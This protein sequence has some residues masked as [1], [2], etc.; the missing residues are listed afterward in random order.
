M[1]LVGRWGGD[2]RKPLVQVE[3]YDDQHRLLGTFS[4]ELVAELLL[5]H[6]R[7]AL[8]SGAV[9]DQLATAMHEPLVMDP[10]PRK[11][12]LAMNGRRLRGRK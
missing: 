1:R 5:H 3:V 8:L 6:L 10:P 2:W 4:A 7:G 11:P 9:R 12:L